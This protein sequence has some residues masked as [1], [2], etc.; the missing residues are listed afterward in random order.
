MQ[1]AHSI[2]FLIE[3]TAIKDL[4]DF[5][6]DTSLQQAQASLYE[7]APEIAWCAELAALNN[8]IIL[9]AITIGN[10]RARRK[11]YQD[12]DAVGEA[13]LAET[14]F[15]MG[16]K[17]G[18]Q[19][20]VS[21]FIEFLQLPYRALVQKGERSCLPQWLEKL[22]V[23]DFRDLPDKYQF[24][25]ED[26]IQNHQ[27]Q[28]I[29]LANQF[30]KEQLLQFLI[31]N[32]Q[33]KT[34]YGLIGAAHL[35][36]LEEKPEEFSVATAASTRSSTL[37]VSEDR[38]VAVHLFGGMH[39]NPLARQ[40]FSD[41]A[42]ARGLQLP[43]SEYKTDSTN[44]S[45]LWGRMAEFCYEI[46]GYFTRDSI[47]FA[48]VSLVEK[49]MFLKIE[50][51]TYQRLLVDCIE[52]DDPINALSTLQPFIVIEIRLSPLNLVL[53]NALIGK[54]E[55][56]INS[57]NPDI[58]EIDC[59]DSLSDDPFEIITSIGKLLEMLYLLKSRPNCL[60]EKI[61]VEALLEKIVP[62]GPI[63][64]VRGYAGLN[65]NFG[66]FFQPLVIQ[67]TAGDSVSL[68]HLIADSGASPT[69]VP[70]SATP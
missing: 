16:L 8:G 19:V 6:N 44:T 46:M 9:D 31:V 22:Q 34:I 66:Q 50:F 53:Q 60:N 25:I 70:V 12:A 39:S 18:P 14:V 32:P 37:H 59:D 21:E 35:P 57:L 54:L 42:K 68:P 51:A 28:F 52:N 64:L 67:H 13:K 7:Q 65:L 24:S 30:A 61:F 2:A 49:C 15:A 26:A 40:K 33:V 20:Q 63:E 69:L 1:P 4:P 41:F 11:L 48:M 29:R 62:S 55:Q 47:Q 56:L 36:F 3:G 17:I 58:E 45:I 10:G 5:K 23:K 38:T 43:A 27:K